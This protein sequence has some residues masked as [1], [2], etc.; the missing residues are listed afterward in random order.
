MDKIKL[1][2]FAVVS[3]LLLNLGTLGFL[4]LSKPHDMGRRDRPEPKHLIIEKLH[5]DKKQQHDYL[6]LIQWHRKTISEI[7]DQIL[8]TKNRLYIQLLKT[9]VD[10]KLKDSLVTVLGEYQ[11]RIETTHFTH[12]QDI[13]RICRPDQLDDYNDL[14][15]EL[16]SIF[17]KPR[18][19]RHD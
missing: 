13:R 2:T 12:F 4:I 15:E 9:E 10:P 11:K 18:R 5:F 8:D 17:S 1:L 6:N 7:E 19:P 16:S 3:L 14:T